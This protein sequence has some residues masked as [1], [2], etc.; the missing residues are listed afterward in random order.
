[1][2]EAIVENTGTIAGI[3]PDFDLRKYQEGIRE[4]YGNL[5]LDSLDT[6]GY[7]YNE[8]KLWRIFIPQNVR[9]V[10]EVL[11]Q[12]HEIPKEYQRRLR[13]SNQLEEQLSQKQLESCKKTY[14]Q[15][16]PCWV[17]EIWNDQQ[18]TQCVVILGDPG[19]GKS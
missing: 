6:S 1:I 16:R 11:P 12:V 17:F 7:A 2:Q 9:E 10:H 8:L 3:I 13:D 14:Y 4:R 5:K 19:S 15:Q 18:K